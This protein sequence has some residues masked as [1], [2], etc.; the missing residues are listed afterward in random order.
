MD[1]DVIVV[2]A[3][4]AGLA[5]ARAL[6]ESSARVIVLE[7]RGRIGGRVLSQP[8]ASLGV[9]VEL[10]AEFIHGDAPETSA[11]LGEADLAKVDTGDESW[12]CDADA[13]LAKTDDDFTSVDLF[14]RVRSLERDE[15]V[16][17]FLRRFERDSELR[18]E[19][20]RA[21]AFVEGFEAADTT[22]A[23]ARARPRSLER[24]RRVPMRRACGP[25]EATRRSSPTSRSDARAR[26][27]TFAATRASSASFGSV[28]ACA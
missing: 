27:S 3:G 18:A 23:S 24:S 16:D 5:A 26:A 8:L 9:P 28:V 14:E 17:V 13:T 21:R 20:Q 4:A 12:A 1:T 15:S 22:R 10:G 6:A 11:Y 25:S 2:G 19:A 7:A